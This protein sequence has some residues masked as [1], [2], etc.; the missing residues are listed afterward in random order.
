MKR[1]EL[2]ITLV[3]CIRED[4]NNILDN[5]AL[6][7]SLAVVNE[8]SVG[9]KECSTHNKDKP[10]RGCGVVGETAIGAHKDQVRAQVVIDSKDDLEGFYYGETS[11]LSSCKSASIEILFKLMSFG[12]L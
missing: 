1:H 8:N 12:G 6:F 7:D 2:D 3:H 11:I 5:L 10:K 4:Y 9:G